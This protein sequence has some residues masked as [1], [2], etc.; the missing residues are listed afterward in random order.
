MKTPLELSFHNVEPSDAIRARV[1]ERVERLQRFF[2]GIISCRVSIE[3]P[4]KS[5]FNTIFYSVHIF[6]SVP[7]QE[8]VVSGA[9]RPDA[10]QHTDVYVA[11]RDAFNVAERRLKD[12]A[13]RLREPRRAE[14]RVEPPGATI[15]Q[16][17]PED[18]Y[19]FLETDDGRRIYFHQNAV[20]NQD[21]ADL[22]VGLAVQ[23]AESQGDEG[24]QAST[25]RIL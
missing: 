7:G 18:G 13:G 16:L 19:G 1:E 14:A 15:A 2:Q 4:A 20:V 24:P 22:D 11:I 17:F 12:Y 5:Q 3:V 9:P 25:V 6:L 10:S 8:I 23:F 21:F